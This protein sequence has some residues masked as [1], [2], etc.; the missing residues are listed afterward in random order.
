M[1][2]LTGKTAVITGASSGIGSSIAKHL[3]EEGA[4]VVLAARRKEKLDALAEEINGI[5][6]GQ[7]LAVETDVAQK[8]DIDNLVQKAVGAFGKIDI[9]IN[10]A[11]L[12]QN[13]AIRDGQVDKWDQMIDVNVKG[14]L[15]GINAVLPDMIKRSAGH[16]VNT[17]SVSGHEVTKTSGVYSATK[18]AVRAISMG[19]EKELA[20]T[21]VRVTNISPGMVETER[22]SER[23]PND[24]KPLQ[25]DDIA[26][27]VVYA[28][29]Q[30]E[31][32]NV[33]EITVRPV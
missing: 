23:L 3:A 18:Y 20:R 26:R 7:A 21:G 5:K 25:T 2:K 11:G 28:V 1:L 31:H 17:D 12:V 10:N 8:A 6:Q 29:A 15:Y 4:N 19:L 22:N 27:A 13:G 32:V 33:N 24:R 14:V 9:F 30:P 16:I